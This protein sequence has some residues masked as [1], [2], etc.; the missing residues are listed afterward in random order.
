LKVSAVDMADGT[1]QLLVIDDRTDAVTSRAMM[2]SFMSTMTETFAH[3]GTALAVFDDQ[4]NLS[5]FN[6]KFTEVFNLDPAALAGRPTLRDVLDAMRHARKLPEQANFTRWR[7]GFLRDITRTYD[8]PVVE[9]WYLPTGEILQ[10]SARP[11]GGGSIVLLFEDISDHVSLERRYRVEIETGQSI[12]DRMGEGIAVFAS[13]GQVIY[14]NPAFGE[15]L[16]FDPFR[17]LSS[18][19]IQSFV[20]HAVGTFGQRE[21]WQAFR[22]YALG[23]E[24]RRDWVC[25]IPR[26]GGGLMLLR[27]NPLP[28]GSTML[29]VAA[30]LGPVLS[31]GGDIEP[32]QTDDTPRIREIGR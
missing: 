1:G 26:A 21:D 15:T 6:P 8:D 18:G 22:E 12:L 17:S 25:S 19:G 16:G 11:H 2:K 14:C 10:V 3:L 29:V 7:E 30:G 4:L 9:D 24:R 27:A 28:D 23:G 32:G 31:T 13:S 5:L 20:D